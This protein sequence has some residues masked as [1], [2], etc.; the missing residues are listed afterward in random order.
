ME[1]AEKRWFSGKRGDRG[2]LQPAKMKF[3][4]KMPHI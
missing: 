3:R 2:W 4:P 1:A